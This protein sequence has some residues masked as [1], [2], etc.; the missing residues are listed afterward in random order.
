M[1][2]DMTIYK[3]H[4]T[5]SRRGYCRMSEIGTFE[6]YEGRFGRGYI[7]RLGCHNGSTRYE[8][9]AYYIEE[10]TNQACQKIA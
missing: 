1:E 5:A 3:Y 9:I 4:H 2:I 10:G 7:K 6:P 8:D